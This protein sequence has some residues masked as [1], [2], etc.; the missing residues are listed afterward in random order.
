[1]HLALVGGDPVVLTEGSSFSVVLRSDQLPSPGIG[2]WNPE[3]L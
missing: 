1:M 3:P 2:P